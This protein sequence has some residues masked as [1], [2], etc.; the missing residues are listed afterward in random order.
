MMVLKKNLS[1]TR[2]NV[3]CLFVNNCSLRTQEDL[4]V[5]NSWIHFTD[6]PNAL[7]HHLEKQAIDLLKKRTEHI[8]SINTLAGFKKRQETVRKTL[9]KIVD[10]FPMKTPLNGK[11][12]NTINKDG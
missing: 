5:I 12:V 11:I 9:M 10:P 1:D 2:A 7:Y 4:N 6:A 3:S 8:N